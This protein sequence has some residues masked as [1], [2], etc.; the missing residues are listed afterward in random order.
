MLMTLAPLS[1]AQIMP[2]DTVDSEPA[3]LSPSTFA[4]SKLA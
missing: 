3:P 1:A 4:F 2:A